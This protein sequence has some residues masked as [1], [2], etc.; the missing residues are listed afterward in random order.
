[1]FLEFTISIT[2]QPLYESFVPNKVVLKVFASLYY[3]AA[4]MAEDADVTCKIAVVA[5]DLEVVNGDARPFPVGLGI[6]R[7]LLES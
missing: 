7:R 5:F 4:I 3:I 1:M 6:S 2:C